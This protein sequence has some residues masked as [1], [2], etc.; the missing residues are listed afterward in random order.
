MK[1]IAKKLQQEG[2]NQVKGFS[3]FIWNLFSKDDFTNPYSPSLQQFFSEAAQDDSRQVGLMVDYAK[4]PELQ[5]WID[6]EEDKKGNVI[7]F[8]VIDE[9]KYQEAKKKL[10][11][12]HKY[13]C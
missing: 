2:E 7:K 9:N 4:Y 1:I 6:M 3:K 11:E 13:N 5:E 10:I 12:Q 8:K